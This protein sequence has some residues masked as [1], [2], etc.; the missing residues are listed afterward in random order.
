MTD[1]P[2]LV[3]VVMPTYNRA[4]LLPNT[5][6]SILNQDFDDFELLIV[7]DG[8]T[9]NTAE[10]IEQIQERDPRLCYLKLAENRGIG[11][12]RDAG[13]KH[14]SGKYIA[15]AD[16]DDHWLPSKLKLQVE[17]MDAYPEIDILFGDFWNIN[18]IRKTEARGFSQTQAGMQYLKVRCI[19]D[20]LWIVD[21]GVEVGILRSNFIA[22]P[23]MILKSE[24]FDKV[25]GFD[26]TATIA[27]DLEFGWRAAVLGA[28]Y[29]YINQP[30]IERHVYHS[31]VTV[32]T[33]DT[34]IQRLEVLKICHS[35]C[36]REQQSELLKQIRTAEVKTWCKL[37]WAYGH[38]SQRFEVVRAF[39]KSLRYRFSVRTVFFLITALLGPNTISFVKK[40]HA[41]SVSE[42]K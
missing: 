14:V 24:I 5:I 41:T 38:N 22:A 13:L 7:D 16:S 19:T 23:T 26:R 1:S 6:E 11:F 31:S 9:D 4:D 30:L 36:I 39:L 21:G 34:A 37:I 10:V 3:S 27:P 28:Q 33:I 12:A 29:A 42:R 32:R 8:S 35:I 25:G 17:V 2:P 40:I 15:L 20:D 18:H